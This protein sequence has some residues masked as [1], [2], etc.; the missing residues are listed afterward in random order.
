MNTKRLALV[1]LISSTFG[2][3]AAVKS[4]DEAEALAKSLS[5]AF[6]VESRDP[7]GSNADALPDVW[8]VSTKD[9]SQRAKLP[10]ESTDSPPD[11]EFR[12]SPNEQWLFGSRHVG[13]GLRYANVYHLMSPL[14][15]EVAGA[16]AS[17]ND[18]AWENCVKLGAL[19]KNYA[20][21]GVYAMTAFQSWSFDSS[22]V[23]IRLCGGEEKRSMLCGFLYFNT[24]INKFEVTDY[25]R[26]LAR[27]KPEPLGC[28]EPIDPLPTEPE[29]KQR[30][31]SLDA[32]L[33]K[34]YAAVLAKTDK[35][36][37]DSLRQ[38][39]RKWLKARDAGEKIYVE[40]FP[41]AEKIRRRLQYLCDVTAARISQPEDQWEW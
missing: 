28:A 24:R 8:L 6:T 13:S 23:L 5:G 40:S 2:L 36:R 35:D 39:Q 4:A 14:R 22:R 33:N 27:A 31:D 32:E 3:A 25:S 37:V 29:L 21:A 18:L 20:A 11:D 1:G 15:I 16:P 17:F 41:V 7:E 34:K 10:K 30:L 26:K 9:P 12:F 38:G 19:K